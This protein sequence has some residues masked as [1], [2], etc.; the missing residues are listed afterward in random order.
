[1]RVIALV[2]LALLC[3]VWLADA[4]QRIDASAQVQFVR[5]CFFFV[6]W[7]RAGDC[8]SGFAN[9]SAILP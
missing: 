6:V 8:P 9:G 2:C 7:E 1:M 4:G 3:S 5:G